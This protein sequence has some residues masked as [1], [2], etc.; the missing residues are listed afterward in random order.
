MDSHQL[1]RRRLNQDIT[2]KLLPT[3]ARPPP[4]ACPIPLDKDL[5]IQ[6][7]MGVIHMSQPV[8]QERS[9]LTNLEIM[10]QSW[11]PVRVVTED[12]YED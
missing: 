3:P 10:L 11:L 12:E 4:E 6:R 7:L 9:K 8:V 5:L 2:R 1:S